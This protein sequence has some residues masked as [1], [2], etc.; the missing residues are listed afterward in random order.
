M[1]I[2]DACCFI[3]SFKLLLIDLFKN[4]LK[5]AIIFLQD[6][7]FGT[8]V[9]W[10]SLLK[11][12]VETASCKSHYTFIS[13]VHAHSN[14]GSFEL[15]NLMFNNLTILSFKFHGQL[16]FSGNNKVCCPVLVTESMSSNDNRT[17]PVCYQSG[18]ILN[19]YWLT[20]NS[21]IKDV[22]DCSIRTFPHLLQVEFFHTGLI[23]RYGGTLNTYSVLLDSIGCINGYLII[24]L[25]PIF[26][27]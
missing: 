24:G 12:H 15:V 8:H 2:S 21:A 9:K 11:S 4:I 5:P 13:I 1:L 3:S 22:A 26:N 6:G 16:T 14:T 23:R 18:Y 19:N 17:I 27:S 25:I 7:V 20:E 10:P